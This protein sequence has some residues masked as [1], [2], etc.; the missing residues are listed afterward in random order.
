MKN[1]SLSIVFALLLSVGGVYRANAQWIVFDPAAQGT[2]FV[3][4][5]KEIITAGATLATQVNTFLVQNK[6][7]VLDPIA[8]GL[9][10]ASLLKQQSN[11][12]NL[13]T[14]AL[15]GGA[16]LL[17][18]DPEQWI[19]N[20]GLNV[21][22][23]S[24]SDLAG[25][26][27]IYSDS[28]FSSVV[29]TFKDANNPLQTTLANLGVSSIPTTVQ[30]NLC[31][32]DMLTRV[33]T[34]DVD[35][36]GTTYGGDVG[37]RARQSAIVIRKRE[38]YNSL[39]VGNPSTNAQ[40]AS[41]LQQVNAQRPDIG[42][43]DAWLSLTG[44]DNAY[45]QGVR[46]T[47]AISKAADEKKTLAK[48][49]LNSNGGIASPRQ[50]ASGQEVQRAPNGDTLPN[51]SDALCRTFSLTN[52]G[53]AV[54]AAFQ[55]SLNA[56]MERL[57]NSF[58]SGVLS[59]LSTLL[60]A[61]NTISTLSNAFGSTGGSSGGSNTTVTTSSNGAPVQDLANDPE[62]KTGLTSPAISRLDRYS[63]SLNKLALA[64]NNLLSEVAVAESYA[65]EIKSCYQRVK[66]DFTLS[67]N[68]GRVSPGLTY[69]ET[70]MLALA[71][72][73]SA[74]EQDQIAITAARTTITNTRTILTTSNSTQEI[75]DAYSAFEEKISNG[76]LPSDSA[77][78]VRSG[79]YITLQGENQVANLQGGSVYSL[80]SQCS[81][82]RRQLTPV[83]AY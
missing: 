68:D 28:L 69:Y 7:T 62:A 52:T 53:S 77:G 25:Q 72:Y 14:G 1:I 67:Q 36:N 71:S 16:P 58:G 76:T 5:A 38:I 46:A 10:A 66:D 48:D 61:R 34:N 50:C 37:Q 31:S 29:S 13:V 57:L 12:I 8:N 60:S 6:V 17:K 15:G 20:Q 19:K 41:K 64:D 21:V 27:G 23:V 43:W 18:A 33:A 42:G 30:S 32:D 26:S 70:R 74:V 82:I 54:S 59:T 63:L 39:C 49:E 51:I 9:I 40:L 81:E 83:D 75:D 44:G 45:S 2:R 24:L 56:P 47:L 11:T 35:Q 65:N 73:R 55:T 79:D 80:R 78:D 4:L 3:Q 22:Q